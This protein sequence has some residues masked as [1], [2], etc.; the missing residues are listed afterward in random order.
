MLSLTGPNIS[1]GKHKFQWNLILPPGFGSNLLIESTQGLIWQEEIGY[2]VTM[3]ILPDYR[4]RGMASEILRDIEQKLLTKGVQAIWLET[5]TDN[6]P[7]IA[8]WQKHGFRKVRVR[9][10]Y[11][12]GGLDAYSM[13]KLLTESSGPSV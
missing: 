6:E 9:K 2:I 12:P 3:D 4:R 1:E 8:F 13:T 10:R 11:Y 7:A 5:A